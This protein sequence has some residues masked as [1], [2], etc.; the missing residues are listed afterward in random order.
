MFKDIVKGWTKHIDFMLLDMVCL[1]ISFLIAYMIRNGASS[2]LSMPRMYENMLL[3][4]LV[5]DILVIFFCNSYDNVI[6]R[7][8]LVEFKQVIIHNAWIVL[9]FI[10]WLFV[11][12]QSE[13]YSRQII[14]TMYPISVCIMTVARLSW[15][16]IVRMQRK[17]RKEDRKLLVVTTSERAEAVV[18]D[19]FIPYRDYLIEGIVLYDQERKTGEKIIASIPVCAG[20]N[21]LITYIQNNVI[22]EVF[23]D[24]KD[25]ETEVI[26]LMN[27]L[28]NMGLTVHV[29]LLSNNQSLENKRVHSFGNYTVLSASMKFAT[30]RQIIMKRIMDI[31]GAIVG[32][33]FTGIACII[34]GPIIKKQSPG[35]IF[36]SQERV[37]RNGRTFKIWKFRTMYPDAEERKKEL[38]AQNKMNGLMFKMDNDPRIFPIGH[39]LREKS[40]DE[41]PQFWN[42][43]KGD[44][45]L[46]GT[47]PPTMDEYVQYE[48]HHRKRLAMKPGLTGMWQVSG[49]SDITDFEEVVALDAQYIQEWRILLDI[50]ILWMTVVSVLRGKGAV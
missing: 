48:A 5:I 50:K 6:Q 44:M 10:V 11:I 37:G 2:I 8:Y 29:N 24:L 19:L 31:C 39:F 26:I 45:S 1:E 3:I 18:K 4:L 32:L 40:I 43:L 21:D 14:L 9:T 35:P 23:I 49:R 36:F 27:L 7:G 33:V 12:Q 46:V 28:V 47:R 17:H 38:M 20:K 34:F 30:P 25:N 22:D 16:R 42:V 13:N 15:K 41:L